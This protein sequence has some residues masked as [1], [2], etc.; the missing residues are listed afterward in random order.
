MESIRKVMESIWKNHGI[1]PPFHGIHLEF[2]QS[3]P[4]SMHS[5][6][7]DLG[8]VKYCSWG[9]EKERRKSALM[10]PDYVD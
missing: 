2:L 10:C 1:H 4:P 5:I 8:R 7:N 6:W 3:T 9:F